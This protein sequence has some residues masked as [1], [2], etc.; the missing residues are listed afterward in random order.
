[1]VCCRVSP[2][3]KAQIVGLV[4]GGL[5]VMTLAIGDGANDVSMIQVS[6]VHLDNRYMLKLTLFLRLLMWVSEFPEKKDCRPPT[7][8]TTPSVNS[9]S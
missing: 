3:Q 6:V 8:P 5:D 4:K 7:L 2:K 9:G 1:M